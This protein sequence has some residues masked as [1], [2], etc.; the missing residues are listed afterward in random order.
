MNAH[1]LILAL[2]LAAAGC[3]ESRADTIGAM[4][5]GAGAKLTCQ[6][7]QPSPAA[8]ARVWIRC[9]DGA[10][11]QTNTSNTDRVVPLA[12]SAGTK[13]DLVT[14]A[15]SGTFARTA[16]GSNGL[17]LLADSTQTGGVLWGSCNGGSVTHLV[18]TGSAPSI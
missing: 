1:K 11:L 12:A 10:V 5:L 7:T 8:T 13:G 14:G 3:T 17:C 18:T 2:L 9:S 4:P 15:G 16:V 6:S